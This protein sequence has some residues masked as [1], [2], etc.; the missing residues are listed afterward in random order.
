M[1]D[2]QGKLYV[3]GGGNNNNNIDGYV[4]LNKIDFFFVNL[5]WS[6]ILEMNDLYVVDYLFLGEMVYCIFQYDYV[7]GGFYYWYI[8][9]VDLNLGNV[10]WNFI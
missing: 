4:I 3:F 10:L 9:K 2:E 6:I 1:F 7:G 5:I 8:D